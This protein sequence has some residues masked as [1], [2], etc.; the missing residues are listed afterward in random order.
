MSHTLRPS[1]GLN[2]RPKPPPPDALID[3]FDELN[4]LWKQAEEEFSAMR[5]PTPVSVPIFEGDFGPDEGPSYGTETESLCWMKYQ[6]QWRLCWHLK[7]VPDHDFPKEDWKP[8]AE[9][10]MERRVEL[11]EH[12]S[13]LKKKMNEAKVSYRPKVQ[14]AIALLKQALGE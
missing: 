2:G 4:A 3:A 9:C 8:V 13:A 14:K 11:A 10:P 12:L 6:N 1:A 5:L 7:I